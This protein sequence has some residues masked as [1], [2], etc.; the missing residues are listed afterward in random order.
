MKPQVWVIHGGDTFDTYQEYLTWLQD[1]TVSLEYLKRQD[2]KSRLAE[3]LGE[4][5]EVLA[6]RMPNAQNAKYRE[7]K[8]WFEK[9]IPFMSEDLI[10]I[11]HSLGGLFLAKYL[12]EETLSKKIKAT[13]L[14]AAPHSATADYSLADFTLPTSLDQLATQSPTIFLYHSKDDP[15][16]PYTDLSRYQSALPKATARSFAD[17]EHFK[18][19]DFPELIADIKSL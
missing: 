3:T 18:Q 16:V 15:V 2:W 10:F 11:G 5:Y 12:S 13:L 7:W 4:K 1:F 8:L 9:F 17:R 19:T 6:P 14:I